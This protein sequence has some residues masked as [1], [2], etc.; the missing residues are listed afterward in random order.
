MFM[1]S[2]LGSF[3]A[4]TCLCFFQASDIIDDAV[5]CLIMNFIAGR[6]ETCLYDHYVKLSLNDMSPAPTMK[7]FIDARFLFPIFYLLVN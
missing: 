3:P 5:F 6:F 1:F 4:Q 7:V 2:P